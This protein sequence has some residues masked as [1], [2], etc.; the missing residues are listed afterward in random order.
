ME[1]CEKVLGKD[2]PETATS[3]NNNGLEYYYQG[4]HARALQYYCKA[5]EIREKVLGKDHP[6]TAT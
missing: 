5:L 4:D 1:I 3:Y 6:E 2:H